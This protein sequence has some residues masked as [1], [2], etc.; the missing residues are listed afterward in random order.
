MNMKLGRLALLFYVMQKLF[1][2]KK[3]QHGSRKHQLNTCDVHWQDIKFW[4]IVLPAE[5]L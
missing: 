5:K 2:Y 1:I 3:R 4:E